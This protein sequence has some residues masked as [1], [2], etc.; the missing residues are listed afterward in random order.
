[1]TMVIEKSVI[2]KKIFRCR[3][4]CPKHDC[5]INIRKNSI[6]EGFQMPL[7]FLYYLTLE[8]FP[9]NKSLNKSLIEI[10]EKCKKINKPSTTNKAIIKLFQFLKEKIRNKN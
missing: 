3:G 6:Y 1:M 7:F 5:K 4:N 10:D 8:C 2:D 9:F